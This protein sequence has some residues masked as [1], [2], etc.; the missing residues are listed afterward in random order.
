MGIEGDQQCIGRGN[1]IGAIQEYPC[2]PWSEREPLSPKRDERLRPQQFSQV[3]ER[4][5]MRLKLQTELIPEKNRHPQHEDGLP[6]ELGWRTLSLRA[7]IRGD[8]RAPAGP[9]AELVRREPRQLRGDRGRHETQVAPPQSRVDCPIS[10]RERVTYPTLPV[11]NGRTNSEGRQEHPTF[12]WRVNEVVIERP[13]HSSSWANHTGIEVYAA[14]PQTPHDSRMRSLRRRRH[15]KGQQL[16][17][18]N[19]LIP[20]TLL[21]FE[22]APP[23]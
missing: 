8:Q 7:L 16:I 1:R 20:A 10:S 6:A 22:A 2:P 17:L 9:F 15:L 19:S 21:T 12:G 14:A 5:L 13:S 11:K 3:G 23:E 18:L 4:R